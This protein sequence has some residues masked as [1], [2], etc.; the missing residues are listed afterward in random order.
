MKS[1]PKPT[2]SLKRAAPSPLDAT[3]TLFGIM[4]VPIISTDA[5]ES[6]RTPSS[7]P[8]FAIICANRA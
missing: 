3:S 8:L 4:F 5:G 2:A 6:R 7:S 1:S